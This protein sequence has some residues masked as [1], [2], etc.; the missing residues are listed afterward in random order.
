MQIGHPATL[1]EIYGR[2]RQVLVAMAANIAGCRHRA[3]DAV[4]DAFARL[5]QKPNDATDPVAYCF[6][7][8]RNAA[9]NAVRKNGV[10]QKAVRIYAA[11]RP[12]SSGR[13]EG[14]ELESN[15]ETLAGIL[16]RLPSDERE[17]I[18]LKVHASLTYAQI[19][20]IQGVPLKTV[21]TRYRRTIEELK[22]KLEHVNEHGF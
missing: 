7:A 22:I 12:E 15:A 17:L 18:L 4:H 10:Q 14:F 3:E 2:Y 1:A 11:L 5:V 21:A 16:E 13:V 20:E 6:R 19:G 8:V 9:I